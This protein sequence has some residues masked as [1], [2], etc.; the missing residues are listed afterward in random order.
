MK[1]KVFLTMI[2]ASFFCIAGV[3]ADTINVSSGDYLASKVASAN[4]GDTL[5]IE[6]GTYNGDITITKDITLKGA[7]KDGVIINGTVIVNTSNVD[8]TLD[9]LTINDSS[10]LIDIKA[11]STVNVNNATVAYTGYN[12]TYNTNSADGIW[13]ERTANGT[14]LNITNSDVAAKYAVWVSGADNNISITGSTLTGYAA[15]DISNGVSQKPN[16]V[17][18]NIV[19]VSDSTLTG[20]NTYSGSSDNYGTIVIGGQKGLKLNIDNSVVTNL[21]TN[22]VEDL[23]VISSSYSVSENVEINITNSELINNAPVGNPSAVYNV[24][25]SSNINN[26]IILDNTD[27]SATNGVIYGTLA[28]YVYVTINVFD[29]QSVV[30]I[31]NGSSLEGLNDYVISLDGYNFEGWFTDSTY[32]TPFDDT[33]PVTDNI[34]LYA[35]YVEIP[36]DEPVVSDPSLGEVTDNYSDINKNLDDVPYT[37]DLFSNLGLKLYV[38]K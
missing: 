34:N 14:D 38:V 8:V 9:S 5:V 35:K 25:S 22:V 24:T 16:Q 7:S 27:V 37:G 36:Q 32:E 3:N 19:N 15:L 6:N 18:G 17:E 2:F 33:I 21:V 20:Y 31:P 11:K 29:V 30:A 23:I 13:V 4:P 12:G 1:F 26:D 28:D 10:T